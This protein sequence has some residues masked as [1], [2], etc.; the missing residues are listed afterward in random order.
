MAR[1]LKRMM[2]ARQFETAYG[3]SLNY[4][5]YQP[6]L[7]QG[8]Q[9]PLVVFLHG[10]GERGDDNQAQMT[11]AVPDILT[12]AHDNEPAFV[13]A[14]QCPSNMRWSNVNGRV[15]LDNPLPEFPSLPQKLVIEL[16]DTLV[17]ELP[18][19]RD[20]LYLTG[21][22]LGGFGTLDMLM[23]RPTTFAAAVTVC[24][25]GDT[26]QAHRI[27]AI[28]HWLFHGDADQVIDVAHSRRMVNALETAGGTP[29]YTEYASVNHDAWTPTYS[30]PS[31]LA[32]LF[33]Q[34]LSSVVM[35]SR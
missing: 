33:S 24:G 12:H 1:D 3:E 28:P 4:R 13:L 8:T 27:A 17:E 9:Y 34:R 19:D 15:S 7:A 11:N 30:D 23:R 14:P 31:V 5:L 22:S 29:R 10:S 16:L 18:I 35:A 21:L 25:G 26:H 2:Q 32:W 6:D 20:R